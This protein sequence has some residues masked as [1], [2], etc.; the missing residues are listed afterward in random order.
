MQRFAFFVLLVFA[1]AFKPAGVVP[2]CTIGKTAASFT[3]DNLGNV[4]LTQGTSISKYN[5][6]C[7][8]QKEFSNKSFGTIS[9][10]DATNALR[11]VLFYRDFSRVVFLD[12]TMSQNGEAVQLESLGFPMTSLV[13]SSHDNGLWIFDQQNFELVRFNQNMQPEQ[14][15]G[16]LSQLLG[17]DSLQPNFLI[18]KDN[19]LFLNNP[20]TGVLVFD[21]FGTYSKTI[22]VLSLKSLQVNDDHI[23]YFSGGNMR[24]QSLLTGEETLYTEPNDPEAL[25][26]RMEKTA[27]Y[28][29]KKNGMEMYYR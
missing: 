3:T 11:I 8:F 14:R 24:S 5:A 12:N 26:M 25:D 27:V 15:T 9:S 16:N 1:F 22:P 4:Y 23:L 20:S 10:A 21:V 28:V 18:E 13:A 6:Q 7:S 2:S 17:I 19:K 29:L